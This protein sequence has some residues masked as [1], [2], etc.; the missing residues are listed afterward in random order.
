MMALAPA[1]STQAP[2]VTVRICWKLVRSMLS[3]DDIGVTY[4]GVVTAVNGVTI[5]VPDKGV[6]ALLGANGAGKTTILRA[7]TG[8]LRLH[9][10]AIT[11]GAI[12]FDGQP[13]SGLDTT[14]LVRLGISQVLE[15]R[16]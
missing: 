11:H 8:L 12:L 9:G 14:R 15:G 4:S 5:T 10:G 3:I 6:V 7:I 2:Q 13:I 1:D 16:R